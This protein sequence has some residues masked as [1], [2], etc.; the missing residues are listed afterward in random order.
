MRRRLDLEQRRRAQDLGKRIPVVER[1]DQQQR[2]RRR[3]QIGHACPERPLQARAER[4]VVEGR[5][6]RIPVT[7]S[8]GKLEQSERIAVRVIQHPAADMQ[9]EVG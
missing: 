7:P 8:A 2:L 3:G 5:P 4:H 9:L 6:A 1:R